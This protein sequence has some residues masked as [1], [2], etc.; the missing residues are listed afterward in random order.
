MFKNKKS[1][2]APKFV[3]EMTTLTILSV[4]FTYLIF[5]QVKLV[6]SNPF[7]QLPRR[8]SR[9]LD[10]IPAGPGEIPYQISLRGF[11]KHYCGAVLAKSPVTSTQFV[12]TAAECVANNGLVVN[13]S[14]LTL[15]AGST[16]QNDLSNDTAQVIPVR[17]IV[18]YEAHRVDGTHN[19][20]VPYNDI[21][22]IFPSKPFEINQ[23]VKPIPLPNQDDD[24]I[25]HQ[26][27]VRVSGWGRIEVNPTE[28]PNYLQVAMLPL[29]EHDNCSKMY[30]KVY[31]DQPVILQSNI[32]AGGDRLGACHQ[33]CSFD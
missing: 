17:K 8:N 15:M 27:F 30:S 5:L 20:P 32:C 3:Q 10:G 28:Y 31:R 14:Q 26:K 22:I 1:Q 4:F 2:S 18:P 21:A 6:T 25:Y 16:F 33:V 11:G 29:V 7:P 9:I 13:T 12:L 19:V 24:D 23:Y